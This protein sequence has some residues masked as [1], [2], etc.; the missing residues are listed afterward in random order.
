MAP[1]NVPP[2]RQRDVQRPQLQQPEA[3]K[4]DADDLFERGY[5]LKESSPK[6]AEQLFELVLKKSPPNSAVYQRAANYLEAMRRP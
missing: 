1:L 4:L 5:M 2:P 3:Q 6:E